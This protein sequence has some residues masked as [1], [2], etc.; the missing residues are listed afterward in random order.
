V[1][2]P[3][4]NRQLQKIAWERRGNWFS[5]QVLEFAVERPLGSSF[6]PVISSANI[7]LGVMPRSAVPKGMVNLTRALA[8]TPRLR[9]WFYSLEK[10]PDQARKRAFLEMAA[11][12]RTAEENAALADAVAA[13]ARPKLYRTVL[14]TVNELVGKAAS[15]KGRKST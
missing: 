6:L 8:E 12:M 2:S 7:P 10:L 1:R 9:S 11:E 13:L 14:Q 5:A 15:Q 3:D 4:L